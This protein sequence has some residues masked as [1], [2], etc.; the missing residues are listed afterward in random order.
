MLIDGWMSEYHFVERHHIRVDAPEPVVYGALL[1]VDV[2]A[3]PVLRSLFALR[4]LPAR[5]LGREPSDL[6]RRP[7]TLRSMVERGF[8]LLEEREPQEVVLGVTGRFW[9]LRG[10]IVATRPQDFHES[11][12]AG[13]ARVAWNFALSAAAA[14]GTRLSTE[15]RIR[16][17][18]EAARR[19]F[20]RYWLLVRPGSGWIRRVML[21]VVKREAERR[22]A[23]AA[24]PV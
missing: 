15:T 12:P 8:V 17:A 9:Q 7:L 22:A 2:G 1:E 21:R 3:H 10:G 23:R 13:C 19:A 5:L 18:D 6:A 4:T 24:D 20:G 11:V 14:G 16:C